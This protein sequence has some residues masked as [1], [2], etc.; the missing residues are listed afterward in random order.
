[1][2]RFELLSL[3][4]PD[5]RFRVRC[6]RGTYARSLAHDAGQELGCGAAL[7]DLRRTAVGRHRIEEAVPLEALDA[8]EAVERHLRPMDA[9]LDLPEVH[10]A[11]D[12]LARV[13]Q[14]NALLSSDLVAACPVEEGWVQ[15]KAA[16]GRLLAVGR[17]EAG[18]RGEL[19]VQPKRVLSA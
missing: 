3:D 1:V 19:R 11:D 2:H 4:P 12:A 18:P 8:P 15:I 9:A 14:G 16:S 7:A 5:V 6:S 13:S 10:V 17:A